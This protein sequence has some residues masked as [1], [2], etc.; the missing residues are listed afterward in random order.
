[1]LLAVNP[2]TQLNYTP[3][4]A[5]P[6]YVAKNA[7]LKPLDI[8]TYNEISN[9]ARIEQVQSIAIGIAE[10]AGNLNKSARTIS[11]SI[12][13]LLKEKVLGRIRSGNGSVSSYYLAVPENAELPVEALIIL[14]PMSKEWQRLEDVYPDELRVN[15]QK[16]SSDDAIEIVATKANAT[17]TNIADTIIKET[18]IE[19]SLPTDLALSASTTLG[20]LADVIVQQVQELAEILVPVKA[21]TIPGHIVAKATNMELV[22]PPV[23]A[24]TEPQ[25]YHNLT[26]DELLA[27]RSKLNLANLVNQNCET[28]LGIGLHHAENAG[29]LTESY[30]VCE[31]IPTIPIAN[32]PTAIHVLAPAVDNISNEISIETASN[33]ISIDHLSATRENS[34]RQASAV[35]Q[36]KQTSSSAETTMPKSKHS[37]DNCLKFAYAEAKSKG[38]ILNPEGFGR[39]IYLSGNQDFAIGQHL[40]IESQLRVGGA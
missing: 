38:K 8:F 15:E 31:C 9:L 27:L 1:M 37:L 7:N 11:R 28:C 13:R 35:T 34:N 22:E 36:S 30:V 3:F 39:T 14:N 4:F 2:L 19:Q 25:I 32:I 6:L 21:S 26:F 16:N 24:P 23:S 18:R 17:P 33:P 5:T 20:K 40:R 12:C 29:W 10:I